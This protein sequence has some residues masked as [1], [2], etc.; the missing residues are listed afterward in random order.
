MRPSLRKQRCRVVDLPIITYH[1]LYSIVGLRVLVMLKFTHSLLYSSNNWD[2]YI[3]QLNLI[4][5][6]LK[7]VIVLQSKARQN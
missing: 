2:I 5:D 3:V 4:K 7:Y 1:Y 6:E